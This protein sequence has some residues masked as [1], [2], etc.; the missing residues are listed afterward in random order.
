MANEDITSE[1]NNDDIGKKLLGL[2]SRL[3]EYLSPEAK[4]RLKDMMQQ[5]K[6]LDDSE[7]K[8]FEDSLK[9]QL[10]DRYSSALRNRY[11]SDL[12]NSTLVGVCA[13]TVF[14]LFGT[15]LVFWYFSKYCILQLCTWY[16][17]AVVNDIITLNWFL[18]IAEV[19]YHISNTVKC[20]CPTCLYC[21]I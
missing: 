5:Y 20:F 21:R 3:N 18:G 2:W 12:M 19:S 11:L 4:S 10:T 8:D 9:H 14:L 15:N 17:E 1:G 6:G 7:K 13:A 16:V